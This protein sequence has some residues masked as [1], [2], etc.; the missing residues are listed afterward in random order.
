MALVRKH[1]PETPL[2]LWELRYGRTTAGGAV[3]GEF[4]DHLRRAWAEVPA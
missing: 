2:A 4:L 1:E 3:Q